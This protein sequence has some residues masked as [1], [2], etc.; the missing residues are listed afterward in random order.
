VEQGG[1]G[2]CHRPRDP[3]AT[4]LQ[5][6]HPGAAKSSIDVADDVRGDGI[7][8]R[9]TGGAGAGVG[10]VHAMPFDFDVDIG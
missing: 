10:V 7:D 9:T 4:L 6:L 2:G 5:A 1:E 8:M 3:L